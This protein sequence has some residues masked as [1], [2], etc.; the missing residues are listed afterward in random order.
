MTCQPITKTNGQL[1]VEMYVCETYTLLVLYVNNHSM[2]EQIK[3][4]MFM[5]LSLISRM[6]LF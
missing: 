6:T 3:T 1:L 2:F 5:D 4:Y